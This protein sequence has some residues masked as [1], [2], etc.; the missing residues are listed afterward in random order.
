MSKLGDTTVKI[1]WE[2][3]EK[4]GYHVFDYTLKYEINGAK[5]KRTFR[6]RAEA[7]SYASVLMD[8]QII[9]KLTAK[10]YK[11]PAKPRLG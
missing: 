2:E 1:G 6:S 3:A 4:L 9:P 10:R 11:R 5:F 8:N 7:D